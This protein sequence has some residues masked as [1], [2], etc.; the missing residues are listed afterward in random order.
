MCWKS[1]KL[2][3]KNLQAKISVKDTLSWELAILMGKNKKEFPELA[4]KTAKT[5]EDRLKAIDTL[6]NMTRMRLDQF[7]RKEI[8]DTHPD[9]L[10]KALELAAS[11]SEE[12]SISPNSSHPDFSWP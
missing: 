12:V 7:A 1:Q 10:K 4:L 3:K 5:T 2:T 6:D 9:L 8:V 11:E